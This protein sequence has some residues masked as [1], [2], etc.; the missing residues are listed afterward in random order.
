MLTIFNRVSN[1]AMDS[2]EK[3]QMEMSSLLKVEAEL[4]VCKEVVVCN[5]P[6]L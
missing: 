1:M 4:D 2:D 3:S 6:M 5:R